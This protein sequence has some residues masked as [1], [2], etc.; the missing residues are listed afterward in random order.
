MTSAYGHAGRGADQRAPMP[1]T[2]VEGGQAVGKRGTKRRVSQQQP[3]ETGAGQVCRR[4]RVDRQ[5]LE[6]MQK[7]PPAPRRRNHNTPPAARRDCQHA[8]RGQVA[9]GTPAWIPLR[10]S[11]MKMRF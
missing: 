2:V 4:S 10:H 6:P 9:N 5:H 1:G 3:A 11:R 8:R 7:T